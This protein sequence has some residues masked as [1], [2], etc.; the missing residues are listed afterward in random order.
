MLS[1]FAGDVCMLAVA[2]SYFRYTETLITC[3]LGGCDF[4]PSSKVAKEYQASSE[5]KAQ[6]ILLWPSHAMCAETLIS[7]IKCCSNS[8]GILADV[9]LSIG[10]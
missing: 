4:S 3:C 6:E 10:T 5:S 2:S 9:Y 1:G 7:D 8:N